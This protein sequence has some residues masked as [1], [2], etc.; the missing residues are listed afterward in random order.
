MVWTIVFKVFGSLFS[1]LPWLRNVV[2]SKIK[3]FFSGGFFFDRNLLYT[4]SRSTLEFVHLFKIHGILLLYLFLS[5]C[6]LPFVTSNVS[7]KTTHLLALYAGFE[8]IVFFHAIFLV[9][10][11]LSGVIYLTLCLKLVLKWFILDAKWQSILIIVRSVGH[12]CL[13]AKP[14]LLLWVLLL[15][16]YTLKLVLLVLT[17]S[18]L[19]DRVKFV[20]WCWWNLTRFYLNSHAGHVLLLLDESHLFLHQRKLLLELLLLRDSWRLTN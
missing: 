1:S 10:S 18:I 6:Y 2:L 5:L 13:Y 7:S 14:I 16:V 17:I 9:L 11:P 20:L 4:T 8:L 19:S 12:R 15:T 3:S